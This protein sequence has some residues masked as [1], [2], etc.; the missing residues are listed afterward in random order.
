VRL[1]IVGISYG[2]YTA[3]LRGSKPDRAWFAVWFERIYQKQNGRWIFISQRT[4]H[5]AS[6]GPT[7]ESVSERN[8]ESISNQPKYICLPI[9]KIIGRYAA[10]SMFLRRGCYFPA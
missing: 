8:N 3:S 6:Y 1:D 2:H 5:G 4:V 9:A 7:R 10:V